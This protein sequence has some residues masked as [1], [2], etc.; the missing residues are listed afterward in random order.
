M[1]KNGHLNA[2]GALPSIETADLDAVAKRKI[3]YH[4]LGS[5]LRWTSRKL[6]TI[7]LADLAYRDLVGLNGS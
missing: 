5:E 4:L 6:V 7:G 3:H 1:E 2:L